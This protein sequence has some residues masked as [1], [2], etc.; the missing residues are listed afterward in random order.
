MLHQMRESIAQIGAQ[1]R[2]F[3]GVHRRRRPWSL[4]P[5]STEGRRRRRRRVVPEIRVAVA[6]EEA[7][8]PPRAS[9][10]ERVLSGLHLRELCR[11]PGPRSTRKMFDERSGRVTGV[12]G[13]SRRTDA[14]QREA[15]V[16]RAAVCPGDARGAHDLRLDGHVRRRARAADVRS[17]HAGSDS[18]PCRP[19]S[20]SA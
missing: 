14:R 10:V 19:P 13:S 2:P 9:M 17:E 15:L 18:R 8:Q 12:R 11:L 20:R 7:D 5:Q 16:E 1:R 6:D 3:E 4:A